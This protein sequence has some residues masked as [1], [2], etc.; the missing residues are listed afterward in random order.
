MMTVSATTYGF[1]EMTPATLNAM[2]SVPACA[3]A[4]MTA[5]RSVQTPP[6]ASQTSSP[7]LLSAA[8]P[9]S[10]TVYV[11]AERGST[12]DSAMTEAR[13]IFLRMGG[14]SYQV[15]RWHQTAR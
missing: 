11:L 3:F 13:V 15:A 8:V 14:K 6:P 10:F 7:G 4:S 9:R 12:S 1:G 5:A 2:V